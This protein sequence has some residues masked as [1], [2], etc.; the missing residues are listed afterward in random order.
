MNEKYGD[1]CVGLDNKL[2]DR[3]A[4]T[5]ARIDTVV[6]GVNTGLESF[7]A[8]LER[9]TKAIN[10]RIADEA[11]SA[12]N[13][14]SSTESELTARTTADAEAAEAAAAARH[15]ALETRVAGAEAQ[16]EA[17][18]AAQEQRLI[19]GLGELR[20][21]CTEQFAAQ[22][23]SLSEQET[24]NAVSQRHPAHCFSAVSRPFCAVF[25]PFLCA[26]RLPGAETERTGE[27]WRKMG[28]IW[29]RN[30]QKQRWLSGVGDRRS[31]RT[32]GT[33]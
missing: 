23:R 13:A 24:S 9:R 31:S 21:F 27:K 15:K 8:E 30:G 17:D 5:S 7:D 25:P 10:G 16:Q 11:E 26:V 18:S 33:S 3:F 22:S 6:E 29:G 32:W 2:E 12:A 1:V 19:G 14:L 20:S 28:E 4:E